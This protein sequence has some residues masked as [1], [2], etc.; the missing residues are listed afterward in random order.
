MAKL[1]EKQTMIKYIYVA[2]ATTALISFST[3]SFAGEK[4]TAAACSKWKLNAKKY[5]D[6]LKAGGTEAQMRM[7][8]LAKQDNESFLEDSSCNR[9]AK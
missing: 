1:K 8:S 4:S 7:W 5:S 3:G 2:L 6:L 9:P